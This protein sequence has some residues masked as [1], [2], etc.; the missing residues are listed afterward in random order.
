[1]PLSRLLVLIGWNRVARS[2]PAVPD[3]DC[4]RCERERACTVSL[5]TPQADSV[6]ACAEEEKLAVLTFEHDWPAKGSNY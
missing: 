6:E 2:A 4:S 3:C 1:M 5:A